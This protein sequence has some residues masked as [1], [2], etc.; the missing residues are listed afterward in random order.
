MLTIYFDRYRNIR[1]RK[2][3]PTVYAEKL[4]ADGVIDSSYLEQ[5]KGKAKDTLDKEK[6]GT[7]S[8]C[9]YCEAHTD[10]KR[11]EAEAYKT[12]SEVAFAGKWK[13]FGLFSPDKAD[14]ETGMDTEVIFSLK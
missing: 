8:C 12:P 2:S 5:I 6:E 1:S 13:D 11:I 7:Q 10:S 3:P 14:P 9:D 4:E